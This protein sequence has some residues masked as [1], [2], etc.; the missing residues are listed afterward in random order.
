MHHRQDLVKP[1]VVRAP[2]PAGGKYDAN[3]FFTNN[4]LGWN[5]TVYRFPTGDTLKGDQAKELAGARARAKWSD[6]GISGPGW[7]INRLHFTVRQGP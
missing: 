3:S 1:W 4:D 5:F 6:D 7:L 2:R